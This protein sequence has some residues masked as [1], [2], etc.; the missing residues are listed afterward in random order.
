MTSIINYCT[1]LFNTPFIEWTLCNK[2]IFGVILF[3][4]FCILTIVIL[5]II[6]IIQG[7]KKKRRKE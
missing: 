2:V 4:I 6:Y 3:A 7:I 1:E 5:S